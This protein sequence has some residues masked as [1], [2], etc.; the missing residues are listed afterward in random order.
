MTITEISEEEEVVHDLKGK[1][2]QFDGQE[3][4]ISFNNKVKLEDGVE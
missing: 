2:E 1:M 3:I 4:T